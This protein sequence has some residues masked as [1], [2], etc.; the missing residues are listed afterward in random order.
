[1]ACSRRQKHAMPSK[2]AQTPPL[3]GVRV[4]I[5]AEGQESASRTRKNLLYHI[6]CRIEPINASRS[7]AAWSTT[8]LR[9]IKFCKMAILRFDELPKDS[10]WLAIMGAFRVPGPRNLSLKTARSFTHC[11]GRSLGASGPS[12]G[13]PWVVVGNYQSHGRQDLA[14]TRPDEDQQSRG[15]SPLLHHGPRRL[16]SLLCAPPGNLLDSVKL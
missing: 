10:T 14:E 6:R 9:R 16:R 8:E 13:P 15:I 4:I 12:A 11:R 5:W 7:T 1:M 3:R 2:L